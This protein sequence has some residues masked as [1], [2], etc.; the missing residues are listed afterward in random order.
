[1]G[2][3]GILVHDAHQLH[4]TLVGKLFQET[5]DMAMLQADN[6]NSNGF[7]V[8]LILGECAAKA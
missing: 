5:G 3:G 2:K 4:L 7:A 8:G 6:R 1:M